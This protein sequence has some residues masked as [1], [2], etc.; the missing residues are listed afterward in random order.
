MD[1]YG[2][3]FLINGVRSYSGMMNNFFASFFKMHKQKI[4][5]YSKALF[6]FSI[7]K[8]QPPMFEF[9][10]DKKYRKIYI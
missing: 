2:R 5:G 7:Q 4:K 1:G 9:Y 8:S 3:P 10:D 6:T